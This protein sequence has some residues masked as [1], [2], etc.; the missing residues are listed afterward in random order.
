MLQ[1]R[2]FTHD[3]VLSPVSAGTQGGFIESCY[4]LEVTGEADGKYNGV[5]ATMLSYAR[6]SNGPWSL[7]CFKRRLIIHMPTH[8]NKRKGKKYAEE[9]RSGAGQKAVK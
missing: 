8:N 5:L 3:H 4:A 1:R 7:L 6:R 9:T 2:K